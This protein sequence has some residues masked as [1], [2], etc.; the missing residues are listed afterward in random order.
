MGRL[1]GTDG[2]RGVANRDLTPEL[3]FQLGRAAAHVLLKG[4]GR[5]LVGRD[6]RLSGT[7]LE[8]AL[9]AGITATGVDVELLG[10]IPTPAV[11]YLTARAA[12]QG[13]VAGAMISASHNP[14]ADNGIKFFN[15]EG[16]KLPDKTEAEIEACLEETAAAQIARP[17]GT[18]VGRVFPT[19]RAEEEYLDFLSRTVKER[20]DGLTVVVDCAYGA[21]YR[22]A[23]R[24]LEALGAR[25]Y[26]LHA[27]DD[28]SRINVD[29]GSTNPE[30][31]RQTVLEKGAQVGLAHDGDGDRVIA[32]DEKGEVVD[33]DAIMTVCG[34]QMLAEGRLSHRTIAA[35]V[36]SNLGLTE[37]FK[38][39]GGDVLVTAN[40]DRWVLAAMRE[41]R[42]NLGGEQSGH[43]IFLDHNTTG[44]GV[45]TA[46]Q[47]LSV[48]V[49]TG[50][51]LSQL[52]GRLKRFPQLLQNVRVARKEGWEEN[53]AIREAIAK[54]KERLGQSG[55]IFVRASGTEPLIRVMVEGPEDD[56]LASLLAEVSSVIARELA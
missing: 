43:I 25:V 51:P 52:A 27:E 11:A 32:V 39:A 50:Q 56:L 26:T 9:V 16:Y 10:I 12:Q 35:T 2:V 24:I 22:V 1:F 23:P 33:G 45:L 18:G 37:T 5:M 8:A 30:K 47:L 7:M 4:S 29:C 40:G 21:T 15:P 42:L 38:E 44:D 31:L 3:V 53:T 20:F 36:Y 28:G 17:T 46:L 49:R 13:N 48:L 19:N 6:T 34:L 55:R 14:I 54:A 41:N